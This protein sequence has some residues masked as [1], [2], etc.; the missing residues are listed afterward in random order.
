VLWLS[1]LTTAPEEYD[2]EIY[3]THGILLICLQISIQLHCS[4]WAEN[5]GANT[6]THTHTHTHIHVCRERETE[7]ETH[8]KRET[9]RE[10]E[11]E[12]AKPE[13][14]V[15]LYCFLFIYNNMFFIF[16]ALGQTV[17]A[18]WRT[19]YSSFICAK[20]FLQRYLDNRKNMLRYFV[21]KKCCLHIVFHF[22]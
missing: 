20:L 22:I 2:W 13:G 4:D 8:T 9:Q 18:N 7:R 5:I 11:R 16:S 1:V 6:H 12:T 15:M 14:N 17:V 21:W 3:T 10:R 19:I